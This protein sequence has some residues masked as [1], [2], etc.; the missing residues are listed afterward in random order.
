MSPR[1]KSLAIAIVAAGALGGAGY[2]S[3]LLYIRITG[4]FY[5]LAD[6]QAYRS[7]QLS[8]EKLKSLVEQHGIRSILNLRGGNYDAQWYQYESTYAK[9]HHMILIDHAMTA[10]KLV[11]NAEAKTLLSLMANAP[12]PM[13]IHCQHGSDRT[14]LVSALYVK[15]ILGQTTEDAAKQLSWK[16]FHSSYELTG[17]HPMDISFEHITTDPSFTV[18]AP[19]KGQK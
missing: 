14:G 19:L 2:F 1:W 9:Q 16:F 7:A 6:G 3:A 10:K 11:T 5:P 4:N 8:P 18:P 17:R 15:Y 13:L 12:K